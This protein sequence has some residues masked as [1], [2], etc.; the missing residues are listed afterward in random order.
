MDGWSLLFYALPVVI[1]T[2]VY[3]MRQRRTHH[4]HLRL[5]QESEEAGLT[6]PASLHPVIDESRCLGCGAC[7]AACPEY[8]NHTILGLVNGKAA[9]VNP[10]E[11]IGH[12]VCKS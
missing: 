9:L 1:V 5:Q 3:L 7:V 2:G 10:T 8:P 11:C 12:G 4:A 6:D